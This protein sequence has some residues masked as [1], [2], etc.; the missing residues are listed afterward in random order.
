MRRRGV[1]VAG[2]NDM[3]IAAVVTGKMA[4]L[5][6]KSNFD[7]DMKFEEDYKLQ[8]NHWCKKRQMSNEAKAKPAARR[9]GMA[10]RNFRC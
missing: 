2:T 4:T 6:K 9:A 7:Y 10:V 8:L 3:V 5:R 1:A